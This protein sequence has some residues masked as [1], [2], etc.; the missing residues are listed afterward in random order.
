MTTSEAIAFLEEE[1][2]EVIHPDKP[3]ITL[4]EDDEIV[5][6]EPETT[7]IKV[8]D[9]AEAFKELY[10]EE[11]NKALEEATEGALNYNLGIVEDK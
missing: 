6:I 2:Y 9:V 8:E 7:G 1:G 3:I 5:E 11:V 4:T 10:F